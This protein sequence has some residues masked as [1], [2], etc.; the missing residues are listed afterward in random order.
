M[1]ARICKKERKIVLIPSSGER[2]ILSKMFEYMG[3]PNSVSQIEVLDA[4]GRK[5]KK[6]S[7]PRY[8]YRAFSP[9]TSGDEFALLLQDKTLRLMVERLQK[10]GRSLRLRVVNLASNDFMAATIP[11][12]K[13]DI[14]IVEA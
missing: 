11:I 10:V 1:R 8:R 3:I 13:K 4:R 6:P 14:H 7:P 2:T 12:R 5:G 9:S